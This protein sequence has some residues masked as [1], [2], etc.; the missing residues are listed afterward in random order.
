MTTQF[1]CVLLFILLG[2]GLVLIAF[3]F[4]AL[5]R[6]KSKQSPKKNAIYE[7]GEP[8]VGSPWVRYDSRF[9]N[10]ALVFLLFDVEI[11]LLLPFAMLF[12]KQAQTNDGV[13]LLCALLLFFFL[14][15]LGLAY[16]WVNGN[17][18]WNEE[19]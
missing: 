11:V 12:N 3:V 13:G 18:D 8:T 1:L 9:Y 10:V 14:L 16:E 15:V 7:C 19:K 5:V 6:K 4:S 17:L 2:T